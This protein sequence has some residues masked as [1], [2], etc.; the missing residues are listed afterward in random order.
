MNVFLIKTGI[1]CYT[2][3][4]FSWLK[5]YLYYA[6]KYTCVQACNPLLF[7]KEKCQNDGWASRVTDSS[8]RVLIAVLLERERERGREKERENSATYSCDK[9]QA[10]SSFSK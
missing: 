10:F 7:H 6:C 4:L 8:S 5:V 2:L 3:S 9:S 1:I